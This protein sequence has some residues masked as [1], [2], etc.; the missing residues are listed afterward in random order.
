MVFLEVLKFLQRRFLLRTEVEKCHVNKEAMDCARGSFP[1]NV[2][3][4]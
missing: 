4:I 2:V 3:L 1:N